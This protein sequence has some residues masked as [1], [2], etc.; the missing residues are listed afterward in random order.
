[1]HTHTHTHTGCPDGTQPVN[2]FVD[3]CQYAQCPAVEGA[4]CEANYCGGCNAEWFL[5]GE[6][7]TES[8]QGGERER[9]IHI[10]KIF[11]K[12]I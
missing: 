4:E 5:D 7:V 8:C 2:C 11:F 12:G 10:V 9:E 3:P 6:D 1:M